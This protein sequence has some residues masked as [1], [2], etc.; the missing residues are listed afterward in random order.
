MHWK[1]WWWSFNTLATWCK[2][3]THWKRLMLGKIK[4]KGRK[5]WQR[6][7]WLDGITDSMDM[8]LSKLWQIVKDRKPEALQS[9]R[10]QI[11]RHDLATER[12][13]TKYHISIPIYFPCR[14][15]IFSPVAQTLITLCCSAKSFCDF[16]SVAALCCLLIKPY[17]RL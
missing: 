15:S 3:S 2:E 16:K 6:L 5:G 4:D 13:R 9:M 10:S 12:N 11:V 17:I 14:I 7:R 1:D 8:G